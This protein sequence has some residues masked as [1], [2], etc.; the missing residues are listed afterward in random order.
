MSY[1]IDKLLLK[2]IWKFK[3]SRTVKTILKERKKKRTK[4]EDSHFLISKLITKF[5]RNPDSVELYQNRHI[6]Q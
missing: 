4:L 6:N 3:E 2:C 5:I 1:E